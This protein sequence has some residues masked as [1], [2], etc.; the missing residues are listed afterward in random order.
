MNISLD[1]DKLSCV[2]NGKPLTEYAKII[3][4]ENTNCTLDKIKYK[5]RCGN[6]CGKCLP[7]LK[8]LLKIPVDF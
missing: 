1:A 2:C 7:F 3:N 8:Q 5:Y 6:K 4:S